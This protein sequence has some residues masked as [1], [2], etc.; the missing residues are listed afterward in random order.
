MNFAVINC[1][2]FICFFLKLSD[3]QRNGEY[4][5][6]L[7]TFGEGQSANVKKHNMLGRGS[8]YG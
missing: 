4:Q 5:D 8:S 1:Y 6:L 3:S 7:K 2:Y